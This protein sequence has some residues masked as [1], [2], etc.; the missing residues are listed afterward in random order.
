MG[1]IILQPW[2]AVGSE[3]E[4]LTDEAWL[5]LPLAGPN[6]PCFVGCWYRVWR[7]S[8]YVLLYVD[9]CSMF[10][11]WFLVC[12]GCV[13]LVCSMLANGVLSFAYPLESWVWT[14]RHCFWHCNQYY[15]IRF[16]IHHQRAYL[17]R[18]HR[19]HQCCRRHDHDN[20]ISLLIIT[21]FFISIIISS[22][23][24][25]NSVSTIDLPSAAFSADRSGAGKTESAKLIMSFIA[26]AGHK[27]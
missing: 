19:H 5:G 16:H 7:Y 26:E 20:I 12:C 25:I 18:H 14:F 9:V 22:T 8:L 3:S 10:L 6:I 1:Y 4:S 27:T 2:Y 21:C 23:F 13:F 15:S 24:I 17:H 11:F